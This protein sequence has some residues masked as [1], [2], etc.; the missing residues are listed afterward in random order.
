VK[1]IY[2]QKDMDPTAAE[3]SSAK[4]QMDEIEGAMAELDAGE[5]VSHESVAKWLRSWG[6]PGETKAPQ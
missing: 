6:T 5:G 4:W 1:P 3:V 2:V